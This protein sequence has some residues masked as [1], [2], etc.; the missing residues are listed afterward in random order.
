MP[1]F[2]SSFTIGPSRT[3]FLTLLPWLI[4]PPAYITEPTPEH[5]QFNYADGG[6]M[7]LRNVGSHLQDYTMSQ[8]RKSQS[9]QPPSWNSNLYLSNLLFNLLP[10]LRVRTCRVDHS[11][12][13]AHSNA[14]HSSLIIQRRTYRMGDPSSSCVDEAKFSPSYGCAAFTRGSWIFLNLNFVFKQMFEVL[15]CT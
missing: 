6:S 14:L 12:L 10:K 7:F 9:E 13:S 3:P 8:P 15:L 2:L 11:S 5:T 1:V 4:S